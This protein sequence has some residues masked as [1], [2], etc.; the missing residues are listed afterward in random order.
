[1]TPGPTVGVEE[2]F[3]LVDHGGQ[4]APCGPEIADGPDP[5]DGELQYELARCQVELASGVCA[6]AGEAFDQL[7]ELRARLARS[8]AA[9]DARLMPSATPVLDEEFQPEVTAI[10]RYHRMVEHFGAIARTANTCGCHVHVEIPDRSAGVRVINHLRPWLPLLLALTANSPYHFGV[11]TGYAS[12][13]HVMLAR[14]PS[15]GAPPWF[16]SLD[17]YEAGVD[18]LLRAGALLDKG[19]VY[20]DV[21]LSEQHPTVEIRVSDVAATPYEAA[22][23]A[24]IVRAMV[25]VGLETPPSSDVQPAPVLRANLWRAARDGLGGSCLH[26]VTGRLEPVLDQVRGLVDDL[27]PVLR[28]H[29]D[30]DLTDDALARLSSG[31]DGATRQRAAFDRHGRLLDVVDLLAGDPPTATASAALP[32]AGGSSNR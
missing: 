32:A 20:W 15:A 23:L 9:L 10:P 21:R 14:W 26:P 16:A 1:M 8:A 28:R 3:L 19:M 29:G 6:D 30:L 5:A 2:E 27:R 11:D 25:A 18:T 13:R 12:W 24:A 4:L 17:E 7:V 31:G 22:L